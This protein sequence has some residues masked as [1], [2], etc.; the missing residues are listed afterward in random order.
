MNMQ[1]FKAVLTANVP[2]E[3]KFS[4]DRLTITSGS[5]VDVAFIDYGQQEIGAAKGMSIGDSGGPGP[6]FAGVIVSSSTNQTVEFVITKGD[7][8]ISRV[9]GT[10]DAQLVAPSV[11]EYFADLTVN[12]AATV[13]AV[14]ADST[15]QEVTIVADAANSAFCRVGPGATAA[16]GFKLNPGQSVTFW[17]SYAI[18]IHNP[19]AGA[20]VFQIVGGT[21]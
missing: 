14:A 8:E 13:T 15:R 10:V 5:G 12:A 1:P 7:F 16:G 4:G 18:D 2:K 17:G 21:Q 20:C 19:N 11:G 3:F 9:A 6:R